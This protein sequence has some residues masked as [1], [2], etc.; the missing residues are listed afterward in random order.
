MDAL[1]GTWVLVSLQA[2]HEKITSLDGKPLT[3]VKVGVR[4]NRFGTAPPGEDMV[5]SGEFKLV[6]GHKPAAVDITL[7]YIFFSVT[8]PCIYEMKGRHLKL[9]VP[10]EP[11][12]DPVASL[13]LGTKRPTSF[14]L[15]KGD[16]NW[17]IGFERLKR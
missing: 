17:V 2:G 10:M 16:E 11:T 12:G 8:M 15:G 14:T 13:K 1:Q 6:P 7:G 4:G 9:C 3:E 5:V